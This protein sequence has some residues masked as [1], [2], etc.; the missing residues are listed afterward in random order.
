MKRMPRTGLA[1]LVGAVAI[2]GLPPLNGFVS[3]WLIYVGLMGGD[4]SRAGAV[5]I[6]ALFATGRA[7]LHWRL[8]GAVLRA[9]DWHRAAGRRPQRG[10][11]ARP[12][13]V[14]RH[15]FPMAILALLSRG[16]GHRSR[17]CCRSSPR[18]PTRC[19]ATRW[20]KGSDRRRLGARAWAGQ[21]R[22]VGGFGPRARAV[23]GASARACTRPVETWGCGYA[24]PT[25]RMQYTARSFSE[26]ISYRLLP[27]T[28]RPRIT[29]KMP[30]SPFPASGSFQSLHGSA[31]PRRVRA[32]LRALGQIA[33]RA[34]AG[35]SREPCTSTCCTSSS[36][37]SR[38]WRGYRGAT[39]C[40]YERMAGHGGD[41]LGRGERR[42]RACGRIGRAAR[43]NAWPPAHGGGRPL[44]HR[45]CGAG[46]RVPFGRA[47]LE[48]AGARRPLRHSHRRHFRA[49]RHSDLSHLGLGL[50]VRARLLEA[51]RAPARRQKA[52]LCYGLMTARH[53]AARLR[54]QHHAVHGG[55]GNHGHGG[56]SVVGRRGR[57]APRAR[58]RLRLHGC[59]APGHA[60][61]VRHV[62]RAL[63]GHWKLRLCCQQP[64]EWRGGDGHPAART[65]RV[66]PQGRRDAH[67]RL[68]AWRPCQR[69]QPRLGPHVRR[70]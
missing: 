27:R 18:W 33:S 57:S 45:R 32:V 38:P 68:V 7:C 46:H 3:E 44:W 16:H 5:N 67:A 48:L 8:G 10:R 2:A 53:G 1:M 52:A 22:S 30:A 11:P 39:G 50:C 49:L 51:S 55:L 59:H 17:A 56:V 70:A 13:V 14:H 9:L 66:R 35:F 65:R 6:A 12:R 31:D 29:K 60:V 58:G 20:P 64:G 4:L 42:A 41:S 40:R 19:S 63:R 23:G 37:R 47:G 15:A 62:R 36:W 21:C 54:T 26:F 34:C 43:A 24:A 69:A 61:P 28:M 25:A